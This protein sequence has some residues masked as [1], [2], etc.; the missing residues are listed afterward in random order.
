MCR[1]LQQ[2]IKTGGDSVYVQKLGSKLNT[3]KM[4][5]TFAIVSN[6][7]DVCYLQVVCLD[8]LI[9]YKIIRTISPDS[10]ERH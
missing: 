6:F 9:L 2:R 10:R 8:Y 7:Y 3:A 4:K 1:N 5:Q